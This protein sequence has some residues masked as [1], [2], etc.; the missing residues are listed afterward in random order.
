[1]HWSNLKA[2]NLRNARLAQFCTE[3]LQLLLTVE[4]HLTILKP[5]CCMKRSN[6]WFGQAKPQ[7]TCKGWILPKHCDS[8]KWRLRL[9]SLHKKE[10]YR[11]THCLQG[12]GNPPNVRALEHGKGIIWE[13]CWCWPLLKVVVKA[14]RESGWSWNNSSNWMPPTGWQLAMRA[15]QPK[16]AQQDP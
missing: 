9:A 4:F 6:Q 2:A 13:C 3:S 8:K 14:R 1:M 12:F 16:S 11:F 7:M 15:N 5:G 10:I